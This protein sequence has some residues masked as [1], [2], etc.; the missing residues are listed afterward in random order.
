[1][2]QTSLPKGG[3][4]LRVT[5]TGFANAIQAIGGPC[6]QLLIKARDAN[7]AVAGAG[8]SANGD[9]V[10]MFVGEEGTN[11]TTHTGYTLQ[12]GEAITLAI[13]DVSMLYFRGAVGDSVNI[14]ILA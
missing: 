9:S 12:P 2:Y 6:K 13:K 11:S 4:S 5:C 8:H 10:I 14:I 7:A 1:M 3:R